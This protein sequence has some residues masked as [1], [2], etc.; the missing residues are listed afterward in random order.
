MPSVKRLQK[1]CI[2]HIYRQS[3][4]NFSEVFKLLRLKNF[5]SSFIV[6]F[7]FRHPVI[8]PSGIAVFPNE[9]LMVPKTCMSQQMK[10]LVSYNLMPRGGHFAALEEPELLAD[11][12]WQFVGKVE[13]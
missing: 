10:N 2:S 11:D 12:I 6:N 1:H 13:K 5:D 9:V 7:H 8:V 3:Q 4:T